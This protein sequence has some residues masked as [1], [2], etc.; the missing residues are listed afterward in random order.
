Y[1]VSSIKSK[2][3][4][5]FL[6]DLLY[7]FNLLVVQKEKFKFRKEKNFKTKALS[8]FEKYKVD[9]SDLVEKIAKETAH[10]SM[11]ITNASSGTVNA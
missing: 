1:E 6:V 7:H 3:I 8:V 11:N 5:F 2:E 9:N 10:W 4:I